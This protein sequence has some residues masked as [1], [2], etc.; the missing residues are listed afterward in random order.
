MLTPDYL[1][2]IEFNDV[3]QLYNQ[4][5][6]DIT[7]DIITRVSQM[8]YITSTTKEQMK[9]ILQTNGT[10]IFNETLEKTSMLSA[11]TKKALKL[12]F[13]NMAKEDI[14]GYK[15]L[16]E[17]RD[18]PFK[19]SESQYKILN[20]GLR[21]TNK[22][23]KNF[24]N[25]IAFS[26]KQMYVDAVDQAYFQVASGAFSYDTAINMACQELADKGITLKDKKG[27]NVQLEVAVRR[28]IMSGIQETANHLNRDI[29]EELGCDG[30]EVTAHMGARPTHA[31]EQG[32]QFALNKK[33]ASKFGVGLWSD[34]ED[35]WEEYNC[36]HSYFG[37]ILGVSEPQ[38]NNKELT[39]FKDATVKYNGEEIPYYEATQKQ[40][41]LENNIR[42]AKRSV[43]TLEQ[44]DI[45]A[46]K[47][48]SKLTRLQKE[49]NDFCKETGLEKDYSRIK[50]AK[51]NSTKSNNSD[52][53]RVNYIR[54]NRYTNNK[55]LDTQIK[56]S[57]N[58]LPDNIKELIKDT[59]IRTTNEDSYYDR[60]RDIIYLLK[61][62]N[63]N[64]VMHEFGHVIETKLDLMHTARYI[65]LQSSGMENINPLFDFENIDGYERIYNGKKVKV[66]FV[67]DTGKFISE[68]Q[69]T[70]YDEDIDENPRIY[71][72]SFNAK[73][74]GEYFSEG[75]RC[76]F[77]NKKLLQKKDIELY[78]Y[79]KEI[80]NG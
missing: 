17:Y 30:Y 41:T 22:T 51:N 68:Y 77:Q 34:V 8:N 45:D 56:K 36:R 24:T 47:V 50:V 9:V 42:K 60:K 71:N 38:Y 31:E 46:T 2:M 57:I 64:E 21:Q 54:K 79:I 1:N 6:I 33:D 58:K 37:I 48:K 28:N 11:E 40:R 26:S 29:E 55:N 78:R 12:M 66:D 35:L 32:K 15:E 59:R 73:V 70:I 61:D 13:E 69:R 72:Y 74:L 53:I 3:V 16:Y 43:Q 62:A 75:F 23:L 63:K 10:E 39:D 19:L 27:R 7:A 20:E 65:K 25:T 67:K 44:T 14:E 52:K 4:L 5:N 49:Y 18:K 80:L 76:Y